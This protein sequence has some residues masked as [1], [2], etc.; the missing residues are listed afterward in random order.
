MIWRRHKQDETET[1][2]VL[3]A[4]EAL[5]KVEADDSKVDCLQSEHE[6]RLR[7][8]DFGLWIEAAFYSKR[9]K[10]RRSL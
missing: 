7:R 10:G 6:R 3:V 9:N 8:N 2:G 5:E 4:R 1:Q